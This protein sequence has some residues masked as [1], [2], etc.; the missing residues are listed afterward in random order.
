MEGLSMRRPSVF[1]GIAAAGG[2]MALVAGLA[3]IDGRVRDQV[4]LVLRGR[5]A[6]ASDEL[7]TIGERLQ[8]LLLVAVQA[9]RNQSIEHAPLV[10]FTLAALVLVL[11]M[12][13]T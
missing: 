8:D 2:V 3:M 10:I 4:G 5:P 6:G 1:G 7:A 12:L 9:V 11:F 13:R